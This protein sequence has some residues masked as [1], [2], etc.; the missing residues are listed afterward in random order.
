MRWPLATLAEVPVAD[1]ARP[2]H[3]PQALIAERELPQEE[4]AFRVPRLPAGPAGK[5]QR[6]QGD[7]DRAARH[8]H[9]EVADGNILYITHFRLT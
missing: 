8:Y 4:G 1:N 7:A 6:P 5:E 9:R 3:P 2:D